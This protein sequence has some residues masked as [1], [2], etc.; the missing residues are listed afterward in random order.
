MWISVS[1]SLSRSKRHS[2]KTLLIACESGLRQDSTDTPLSAPFSYRIVGRPPA[3]R[4]QFSLVPPDSVS[5]TAFATSVARAH[6]WML[7]T[8]AYVLA[9]WEE[10]PSFIPLPSKFR[11][12]HRFLPP[13]YRFSLLKCRLCNKVLLYLAKV[14]SSQTSCAAVLLWR[15]THLASWRRNLMGMGVMLK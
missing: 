10:E 1:A 13:F 15:N 2:W 8:A 6:A 11:M 5:C 12:S 14:E 4:Q 3:V 9:C 7:C